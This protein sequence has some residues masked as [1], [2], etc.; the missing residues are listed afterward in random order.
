ME[1][2]GAAESSPTGKGSNTG[3]GA[4]R[5]RGSRVEAVL[6]DGVRHHAGDLDSRL[7][8]GVTRGTPDGDDKSRG[9]SG[10]KEDRVL[11]LVAGVNASDIAVK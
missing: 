2:D 4:L 10:L 8:C 3:G 6:L 5:G 9:N 7:L 11:S 1:G